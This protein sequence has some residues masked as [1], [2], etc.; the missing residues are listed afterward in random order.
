VLKHPET[1]HKKNY[2]EQSRKK[3]TF[4][5]VFRLNSRETK[6]HYFA[7]TRRVQWTQNTQKMLDLQW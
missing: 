6:Q 7:A 5:S 3:N 2:H 4:A 1:K